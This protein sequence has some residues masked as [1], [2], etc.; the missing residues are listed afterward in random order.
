MCGSVSIYPIEYMCTKDDITKT[1][2]SI[3]IVKESK[4]NFHKISNDSKSI[5]GNKFNDTEILL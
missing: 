3:E 5:Q 1:G 4:L 2:T